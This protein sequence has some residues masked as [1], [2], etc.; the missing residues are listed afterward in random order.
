MARDPIPPSRLR[1]VNDAPLRPGGE[2]VLYWM[3]GARRAR[4][5]FGL[6]RAADWA[7][8]LGRPLVVL[9]ALRA[10]YPHA[11]ERLHAFVLR[12]MADNQ[13]RFA[14]LP[15]TYYPYVEPAPGQGRGLLA[16]LAEQACLV[17]TDE[18]PGFFLPRMV[19]AAGRALPV[20]LEAVDGCGLLPLAST[21]RVY[22][23][24]VD[25]RRH[26]QRSFIESPPALPVADPLVGVSLPAPWAIPRALLE[27]WPRASPRLLRAEPGALREL[28]LDHEVTPVETL[29]GASAAEETLDRFLRGRLERYAE[30]RNHPDED[31][32]SGLSP[33]LHFGH[34]SVAEVFVAVT[35]REGWE[36]GRL[37]EKARGTREGFWDL[38]MDAEAF[39][40]QLLTW[41][42]LAFNTAAHLP[43]A[44][45]YESLPAWARET[46]A[47]HALDPRPFRYDV[48]ALQEG[49]THDRLWNAA[50]REL[51]ETGRLQN[52]LRMLWGKKILEWSDSPREA[53]ATML[54]QNDRFAL[55]GRDPCSVAGVTWVLGR[56]DRPWAPERP[57]FGRVRYMSSASAMRKLRL[58]D[59]LDRWGIET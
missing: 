25:F 43:D 27:R 24:A 28:T 3:I 52:Y 42:E 50:Q 20:R 23:R 56:Y 21:D 53:L 51:R 49:R 29:G 11:S 47:R 18:H 9:E 2:Q 32:A 6:Q 38:S 4:W 40:D 54:L 7:V 55:D 46:L 14:R 48:E 41:R 45:A 5:S 39:L 26:L 33:Y 34:L 10:G 8:K 44:D 36:P 37:P 16:A 17:V 35:S 15:V 30:G 57:I 19:A 22:T 31:A 13:E 59:Y 12:G 58:G 1:N